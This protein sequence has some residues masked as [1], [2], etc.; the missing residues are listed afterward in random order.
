M[1]GRAPPA[2]DLV[3]GLVGVDASDITDLVQEYYQKLCKYGPPDIS[4]QYSFDDLWLDIRYT[5]AIM[6]FTMVA[7]YLPDVLAVMVEDAELRDG[8]RI[9]LDRL[10]TIWEM[11]DVYSVPGEITELIKQEKS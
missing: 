10:E 9:H 6:R 5:W 3:Q 4:Q 7:A 2:V 8:M 11:F 1:L